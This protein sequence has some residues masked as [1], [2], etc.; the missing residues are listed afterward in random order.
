MGADTDGD[1]LVYDRNVEGQSSGLES[2]ETVDGGSKD[3]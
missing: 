1:G 2:S 3:E